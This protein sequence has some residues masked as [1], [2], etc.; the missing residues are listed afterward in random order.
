MNKYLMYH[1]IGQEAPDEIGAEL[2]C[3]QVEKFREQVA[4]IA[5]DTKTQRH[6]DTRSQVVTRG[7]R[8]KVTSKVVLTFDDG[9]LNNYTVAYPIL[10]EHN[11]K[12]YFF[13]IVGKVGTAGYMNWEQIR[14]LKDAG[15][16]IGS[17]GMSHRILTE[18]SEQELDFELRVSK[19]FLQEYLGDKIEFLSIP[20]GFVNKEVI[21]KAKELG[22]KAVFTSNAKDADG[23]KFGRI[24]VKAY[25]G[26]KHFAGALDGKV[27]LKDRAGE[28]VKKSSKRI[29]GVR[30][31]D[32]IRTSLLGKR[33]V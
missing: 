12:A 10:K 25:W 4:Y 27:P 29:L 9:L 7:Q 5:G 18:L 33:N 3:V 32:R 23:F 8:H 19:K 2:Y 31:Y 21:E 30:N 6:K 24:T 15:M 22:Y 14:E 11:L 16:I 13:I 1:S 17:H 26:I 28:L 20:R